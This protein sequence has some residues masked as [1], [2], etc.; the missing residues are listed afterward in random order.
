MPLKLQEQLSQREAC[1]STQLGQERASSL[2]G[3]IFTRS[4]VTCPSTQREL[5]FYD[6]KLKYP[7]SLLPKALGMS[8]IL[9]PGEVPSEH[10]GEAC[11]S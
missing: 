11:G 8:P 1:V 9:L 4:G 7:R 10:A 5:C 6:R 3:H 2:P